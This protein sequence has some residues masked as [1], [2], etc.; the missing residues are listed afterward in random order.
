MLL[1]QYFLF[2]RIFSYIIL[3]VGCLHDLG[4]QSV[5]WD[6]TPLIDFIKPNAG[7]TIYDLFNSNHVIEDCDSDCEMC[8]FDGDYWDDDQDTCYC[9]S[10][11]AW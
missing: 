5:G 10:G 9:Y 6:D 1:T 2:D 7:G 8:P 11:Y 4:D 3:T